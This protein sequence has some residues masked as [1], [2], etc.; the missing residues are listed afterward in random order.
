[1]VR[2]ESVCD[3][4]AIPAAT[5]VSRPYA[6]GMTIVFNPS[7]IETAQRMQTESDSGN[8]STANKPTNTSGTATNRKNDAR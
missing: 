4:S 3:T 8:G 6:P 2:H 1:M 5:E 7:G